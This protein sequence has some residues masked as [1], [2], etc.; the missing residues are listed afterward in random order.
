MGR[1]W[2]R[3]L[4]DPHRTPI[5]PTG[6]RSDPTPGHCPRSPDPG[7]HHTA[8]HHQRPPTPGLPAQFPLEPGPGPP[9]ESTTQP[10]RPAPA[11][12]S[13]QALPRPTGRSS[14]KGRQPQP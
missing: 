10:T 7:L 4:Q 9:P 12:V 3:T 8:S 13:V 11:A 2:A 5:L 14:S 6:G 1:A